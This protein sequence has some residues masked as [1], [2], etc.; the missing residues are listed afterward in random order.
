MILVNVDNIFHELLFYSYAAF[1]LSIAL[2][3]GLWVFRDARAR[4]SDQPVMWALVSG[5]FIPFG[6]CYYF[7]SRYR[8][9]GLSQRGESPTTY[10]RLLA[11]WASAG[12]TVFAGQSVV[13]PPDIYLSI[14]GTYGLLVV[15][16]PVMYLLVYCGTY[17]TI[18]GWDS[19]SQR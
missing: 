3:I 8:R 12:F 9:K 19:T 17:R 16:L 15:L 7:Y 18:L 6:L 14:I 1:M 2:S 13:L 11:M 10:D 5:G 4:G